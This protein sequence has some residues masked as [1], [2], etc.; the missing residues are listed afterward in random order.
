MTIASDLINIQKKVNF[1][2]QNNGIFFIN[3][4]LSIR[5]KQE[6][7]RILSIS[8]DFDEIDKNERIEPI[9]N[10]IDE[11]L[12][13]EF[14]SQGFAPEEIELSIFIG[15]LEISEK[16]LVEFTKIHKTVYQKQSKLE[17]IKVTFQLLT[18]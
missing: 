7:L 6:S 8:W 18:L 1:L 12:V 14:K 13:K 2:L 17:N 4:R 15:N 9:N 16:G 11:Y 10:E 5:M 3:A